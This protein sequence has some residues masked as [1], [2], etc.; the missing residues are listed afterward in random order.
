MLLTSPTSPGLRLNTGPSSIEVRADQVKLRGMDSRTL[1]FI[2]V[3]L[4]FGM[5]SEV[6]ET[7]EEAILSVHSEEKFS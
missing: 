1:A 5:N 3:P 7:E 4:A 2:G 6:D